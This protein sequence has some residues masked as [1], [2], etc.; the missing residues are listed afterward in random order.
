MK[1]NK[2][3]VIHVDN[4]DAWNTRKDV[5]TFTIKTAKNIQTNIQY[6]N[7]MKQNIRENLIIKNGIFII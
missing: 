1:N 7:L 5:N 3:R 6:S 2:K 4:K